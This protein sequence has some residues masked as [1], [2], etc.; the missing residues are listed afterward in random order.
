MAAPSGTI[1]ERMAWIMAHIPVIEKTRMA[2]VN[3]SAFA[4]D[5]LYTELRH[6][7]GEAGVYI[8]PRLQSIEYVPGSQEKIGQGNKPYTQTWTDVRLVMDYVFT[9][10]D[11]TSDWMRVPGESRDYGDKGTFQATQQAI[12]YGFVQAFMIA[13]GE[14]DADGGRSDVKP[15]ADISA[16][17]FDENAITQ[18]TN[19]A[20]VF[21]YDRVKGDLDTDAAKT[22]AGRAWPLVLEK[23]GVTV[24]ATREHRDKVIAAA[25]ELFPTADEAPFEEDK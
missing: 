6:L 14:P 17:S 19:A 12:K 25:R 2:N 23:A 21:V 15:P 22:E 8:M 9:A 13:T 1:H 20:R 18:L 24:I 10:A 16:E 4:I 5:K 11:G 7:F 3:Y